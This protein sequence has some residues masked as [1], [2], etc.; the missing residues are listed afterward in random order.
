MHSEAYRQRLQRSHWQRLLKTYFTI[1]RSVYVIR[2]H[3][4]F[5]G[6][7]HWAAPERSKPARCAVVLIEHSLDQVFYIALGALD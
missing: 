7:E 4:R 1:K 3:E 5:I 6:N 2:H